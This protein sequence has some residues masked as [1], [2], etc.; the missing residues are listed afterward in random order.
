MSHPDRTSPSP[1]FALVLGGARSGKSR[2]AERWLE[3]FAPPWTY[4]AT[5]E[6]RDEEMRARIA[7]HQA[8]RDGR[9]ILR[10]APLELAQAV[11]AAS[12]PLL[13]DCLTLWLSNLICHG[14]DCR[15]AFAELES[16]LA[17][18]RHPIAVVSNEV[19]L[20]IVP[21]NPLGRT[22]RDEAGRLHQRLA[23]RAGRVI[24]MVAGCPMVVK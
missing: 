23:A 10:E 14:K 5:G 3:D 13:I 6:A 15:T 12:G 18:C 17:G 16:A 20:G 19:G 7:V 8:R 21:D 1:T 24:F 11:S 9:W 4:V 22:F 2:Y